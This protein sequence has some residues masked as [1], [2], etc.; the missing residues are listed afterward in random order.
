MPITNQEL[1]PDVS[2]TVTEPSPE[3]P[4]PKP[5]LNRQQSESTVVHVLVHRESEEYTVDDDDDGTTA[6]VIIVP[7]RPRSVAGMSSSDCIV[8]L[9]PDKPLQDS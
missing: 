2:I 8:S 5:S 6:E 4:R 1:T 7:E 3:S 9:A